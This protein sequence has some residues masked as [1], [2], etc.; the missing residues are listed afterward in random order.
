MKG[1]SN[2]KWI[3]IGN[4][5][6]F[7]WRMTHY[8]FLEN[9]ICVHCE[10]ERLNFENLKFFL[11]NSIFQHKK[12]GKGCSKKIGWMPKWEIWQIKGICILRGLRKKNGILSSCRRRFSGI[13]KRCRIWRRPARIR[14]SRF[15]GWSK[16]WR[17]KKMGCEVRW[18][19]T[20]R[21]WEIWGR[22]IIKARWVWSKRISC[23][24]L[25]SPMPRFVRK[26]PQAKPK[27]NYFCQP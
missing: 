5:Q 6:Q 13:R 25:W 4:Y 22:R 10:P 23:W 26:T 24:R 20:S 21:R 3:S 12:S 27:V 16:S 15:W 7:F 8:Q 1:S 18:E 2:L 11:W 19:S 14:G 9:G 17:V